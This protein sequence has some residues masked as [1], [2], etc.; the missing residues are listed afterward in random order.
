MSLIIESWDLLNQNAADRMANTAIP[1]P[2][3]ANLGT[4]PVLPIS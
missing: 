3:R 1:T 4:Y 2:V